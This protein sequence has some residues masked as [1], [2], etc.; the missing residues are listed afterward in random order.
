MP[1]R[2]NVWPS[3]GNFH[4]NSGAYA[5][6]VQRVNLAKFMLAR[7]LRERVIQNDFEA[8]EWIFFNFSDECLR[9]WLSCFFF[10]LADLFFKLVF[11][12]SMFC[13]RFSLCGSTVFP[14][15]SFVL[16]MVSYCCLLLC[17]WFLKKEIKKEM[18]KERQ[19]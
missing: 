6:K 13:L 15:C 11:K 14:W 8:L 10:K 16:H 7:G 3:R 4:Q 12:F 17:I 18:Q 9:Y 2:C 5:Q 1:K 19:K